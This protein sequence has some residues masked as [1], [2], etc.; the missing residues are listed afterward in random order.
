MKLHNA[1][2][3]PSGLQGNPARTEVCSRCGKSPSH[4]RVQCPARE[5]VCHKCSKKGHFKS[6]CRSKST[7]GDVTE[8]KNEIA[9]LDTVTAKGKG[10]PWTVN[11]Y[12]NNCLREFKIDTGADVTVVPEK[13]YEKSQDGPLIPPDRTLCGPGQHTLKV[14][15]KF[16]GRLRNG[17]TEIREQIYMVQG[18][19]RPLLGRPAI[20]SLNL[21]VQV[22]P[23]LAQK[24]A[25]VLKFPHL[26]QGLGCM[27]GA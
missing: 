23:V 14:C 5:A 27:K 16:E 7:I 24:D 12:L 15:G 20:E 22:Q 9:F 1:Q 17:N 6:V 13:E 10:Q 4:G 8:L 18:L 25:V 21:V 2:G 19:H 26:F 3:G 11:L